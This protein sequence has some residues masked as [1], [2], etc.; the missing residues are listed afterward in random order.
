MN[1]YNLIEKRLKE[2]KIN[3]SKLSKLSKVPVN[4][5]YDLKHGRRKTLGLHNT[6][7]V[8]NALELDLNEL[9]KIDWEDLKDE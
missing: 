8:F 4:T 3:L 9:R 6:I 5:L 1:L 7:K 2:L